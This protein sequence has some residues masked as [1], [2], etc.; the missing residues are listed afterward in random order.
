MNPMI[1]ALVWL[2]WNIASVIFTALDILDWEVA[3]ERISDEFVKSSLLVI[4]MYI[5]HLYF[6]TS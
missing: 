2:G 6:L 5:S 3:K 4:C 1:P